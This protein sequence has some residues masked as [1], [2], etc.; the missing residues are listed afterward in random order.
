MQRTYERCESGRATMYSSKLTTQSKRKSD[1]DTADRKKR[2]K[3]ATHSKEC[4][5][6]LHA[7]EIPWNHFLKVNT[8]DPLSYPTFNKVKFL[9]K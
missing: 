5:G 6:G 7:A 1:I 4:I 9:I 8:I 3:R 2:K